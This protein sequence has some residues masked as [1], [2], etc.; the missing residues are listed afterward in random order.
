MRNHLTQLD[1]ALVRLLDE[2]ARLVAEL[3]DG[4]AESS[5]L[6]PFLDDLLRRSDGDFP[7]ASL[8]QIFDSVEAGCRQVAEA[9]R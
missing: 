8:R 5:A 2:R 3:A 6:D 1:R 7:A 4:G 9:S